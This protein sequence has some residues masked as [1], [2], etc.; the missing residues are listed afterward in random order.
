[1][2]PTK[3]VKIKDVPRAVRSRDD[4]P[5]NGAFAFR[6]KAGGLKGT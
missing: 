3:A 5:A 6:A 4:H 1:M 2:F